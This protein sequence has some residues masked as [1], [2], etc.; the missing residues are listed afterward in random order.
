MAN[1]PRAVF[2]IDQLPTGDIISVRKIK[3]SGVPAYDDAVEKAIHKSS[4][5]PKK[6]DGTVEREIDAIFDM[7]E[8][9]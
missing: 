5:L 9:P 1:N 7:K 4:P 3:S 6:K 8:T 2:R